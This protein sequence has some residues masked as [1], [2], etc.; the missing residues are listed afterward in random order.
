MSSTPARALRPF[1]SPLRGKS[2]SNASFHRS[3]ASCK[4]RGRSALGLAAL[5][6]GS[7]IPRS[8]LPSAGRSQ[9]TGQRLIRRGLRA[10]TQV[11]DEGLVGPLRPGA[12]RCSQ[13]L[14]HAGETGAARP[15]VR[16]GDKNRARPASAEAGLLPPGD[17]ATGA[18]RSTEIVRPRAFA[19]RGHGLCRTIGQRPRRRWG[20]AGT[21]EPVHPQLASGT[22]WGEKPSAAARY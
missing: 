20:A 22:Y 18:A 15:G 12:E 3:A 17:K 13:C 5:E 6:R 14:G 1:E 4:Q 21:A 11:L 2:R 16:S 7:P 10:K 19:G 8:S 9:A